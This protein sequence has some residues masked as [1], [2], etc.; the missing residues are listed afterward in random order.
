[1]THAVDRPRVVLDCNVLVQAISNKAGPSGQVL[2]YLQQNLIEVFVS[3]AVLKEIRAVL[4]YPTVRQKLPG[5]DEARI[6]RFVQ[7]LAFRATLFRRVRHVF[8][9]PRAKQDEPYI[10]LLS[11]R[12]RTTSSAAI[13][14]CSPWPPII[15]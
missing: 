4:Y 12:R 13:R 14:T 11:R 2:S 15:H 1:M 7:Q 9:Y 5:L 8:D 3:R 10:D 6:D